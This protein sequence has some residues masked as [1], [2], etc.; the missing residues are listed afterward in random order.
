M[1]IKR[2]ILWVVFSISLLLLWDNW[3]R[4]TGKPSMFSPNAAQQQ[5]KPAVAGTGA[6]AGARA[7]VPQPTAASPAAAGAV[8]P[9]T[10]AGEVK[11]VKGE[12]VTITTDVVKAEIDTL[13]GELKRLELLKHRDTVDPSKNLVLFDASANR[14]YL[15]QTGLIGAGN[16][17]P[18]PNHKSSFVAKPGPRSLDGGNEIQLVLEAEQGGVKLTKTYTFKRGDYA[19]GVKHVVTNASGA[20]I[21]PSL[22]L[23]LLR[24]GSKP[25]GESK[26]YSTFTGP[27]VY[28]DAEKFQKLDF[29]KIEAGKE[30]HAKKADNGWV[31]II[32]H[33]F[34][35]AFLPQDKVQRE[36]FTKKVDTNL[37][38]VG[39]I[40]PLGTIA[41][42]ATV[43]SNA[44]LYSGPQESAVL[45]K[46]AP[47]LELVK[48]YGWLTIVAKPIF[49]LMTQIHKILGNWG[50][51][52]IVLTVLIK[53][54]FFPLSAASYRSMAKMKTVTPKMQSIRERFKSDPQKMNQ[55]M[56]ELYKTEKINPLGGCL[57]IVVQIPVF[58]ALYWVLLASVE[59]RNAPWL[60]WIHNLAA[61]DP[62]YILPVVMAVSMFI[63]TKLNPTP[64]DPM[65][66][67]VMMFMPIVFS[68]MF[69]FFPAGL[70]L[71]WVVNNV[72]SIGQQWV[73]TKKIE[74]GKA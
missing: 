45:E 2:T 34:V 70:V 63:Q 67:K 56:M 35:S 24:D 52:I 39:V 38:A 31:A 10:Q 16:G 51:T 69:F 33:Y 3:M 12:L 41:P 23:Q 68:V 21:A 46:I 57:P 4:A 48:D 19:I 64:P 43:S 22:Y 40:E 36:I 15:A 17:A 53:L 30:E 32:Q 20:P 9:A 37:Y 62:F 50:W 74:G 5:A 28:T 14:T 49:W 42:G 1:D 65:Q 7:D 60:G 58:I 55:A 61:P 26:F 18:L 6:A 71:Y 66:A 8:V 11:A 72:L 25:E 73:I 27:A 13:G 47:G 44:V 59:M 54:A 29:E